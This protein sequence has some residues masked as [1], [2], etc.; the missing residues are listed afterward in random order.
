[1]AGADFNRHLIELERGK[2]TRVQL[3]FV[4]FIAA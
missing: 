1:V 3:G 2:D 4:N